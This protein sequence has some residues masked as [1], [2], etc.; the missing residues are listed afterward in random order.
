MRAIGIAIGWTMGTLAVVTGGGIVIL[1]QIVQFFA[2]T[3]TLPFVQ[4]PL[5]PLDDLYPI[6]G[7]FLAAGFLLYTATAWLITRR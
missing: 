5:H 3:F 7:G 1:I 2:R 6:A 4:Q